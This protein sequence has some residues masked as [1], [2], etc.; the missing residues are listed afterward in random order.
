MP[1][2]NENK[3]GNLIFIK[4]VAKYFMDFLETDFHKRRMPRRSIKTRNND[5]LLIGINL[6]KYASLTKRVLTL[7][8]K[9]FDTNK[10][11]FLIQKGAYTTTLPKNL[12]DLI[13]LQIEN[14]TT[15]QIDNL[16][17]NIAEQIEKAKTFQATEYDVALSNSEVEV[18]KIIQSELVIPFIEEIK[19]SLEK[20]NFGDDNTIYQ[21]EDELTNVIMNLLEDEISEL[22]NRQFANEPVDLLTDI[23]SVFHLKDV[24]NNLNSFFDNLQ[25]GDLFQELFEIDKNNTILDKQDFYLYFGDVTFN[26]TKFP[27]FYIPINLFREEDTYNIEFENQVYINKKAIEYIVQQ[28]NEKQETTGNLKTISNRIIYISENSNLL[29][30][31]INSVLNECSHFFSLN[32]SI[33]L[34]S[35]NNNIA[36]SSL[37]TFSNNCYIALSDKSDEALVNDYEEILEELDKDSGEL[38]SLFHNLLNDFIHNNPDSYTLDVEREWRDSDIP[39]RLVYSSPIPLNSEQRQ[40]L[41]AVQRDNCKYIIVE[42]PPGTGKSHT[43]TAIIFDA[44]LKNQSVLVLSDKKEALDVVEDKITQTM[45]KVRVDDNFQNPI[46]RLGQTGNTYNSILSSSSLKEIKESFFAVDQH[47]KG[48]DKNIKSRQQE[49]KDSIEAEIISYD[50]ISIEEIYEKLEWDEY[51]KDQDLFFDVDHLWDLDTIPEEIVNIFDFITDIKAFLSSNELNNMFSFFEKEFSDFQTIESLNRFS[52]FVLSIIQSIESNIKSTEKEH[53]ETPNFHKLRSQDLKSLI[54][55]LDK[56]V[57]LNNEDSELI[58]QLCRE[59]THLKSSWW[60]LFNGNERELLEKKFKGIFFSNSYSLSEIASDWVSNRLNNYIYQQNH[61]EATYR[62][63]KKSWWSSSSSKQRDELDKKI[64]DIFPNFPSSPSENPEPI[65]RIAGQSS[66][67]RQLYNFLKKYS[68]YNPESV[69][70]RSKFNNSDYDSFSGSNIIDPDKIIKTTGV[71][72]AAFSLN[73]GII[74]IISLVH[75]YFND[76]EDLKE[77]K[78][79]LEKIIGLKEQFQT[80]EEICKKLPKLARKLGLNL[81]SANI[82]QEIKNSN[83]EN[84]ESGFKDQVRYLYLSQ[85]LVNDFNG[86]LDVDYISEKTE[87]ENLVTTQVT[88]TLDERVINFSEN[89]RNDAQALRNIIRNKRRFPRQEFQ[90]LKNAFP[91]ILAGIRDFSEYIPLESELFDL[92]II[93]EASQVSI[94]QAFPALIRA[95]KVVILGDNKQFS[96]IKAQQARS[97]T[98]RLYLNNLSTT[99]KDNISTDAV[100]IERLNKFN[101]KTSILEFFSF[102]SNFNIQLLKYF[103][104]YKEIISYSNDKFYNN[105]QVMKIRGKPIDE[106]I[107]FS[108]VNVEETDEIYPNTNK[109]EVEFIIKELENLNQQEGN[110][111]VGIIT[112]HTNQQKLLFEMISKTN[113]WESYLTKLKLKIMTFDTCQGEERDIIFY[114]M[115]ASEHSDKLWGVFIKDLSKVDIEQDGS[116]KAQRLN[117]GFSRAKEC[118]HFILSK[119]LDEFSGSIGEA[120]RHYQ[121]QLEDA[122]KEKSTTEVDPNSPMEKEVMNWFYQT[123]FYKENKNSID[124]IPQFEIG[125]YLKQLEK[126]YD[127]PKYKVDFLLMYTDKENNEHKIVLEYDGFAEHFRDIGQVDKYNYESFYS[128]DDVYRQKVLESYGYK[129]IR[130]NKFNS[131]T[132]PIEVLNKRIGSLLKQKQDNKSYISRV[133]DT[134]VQLQEG[135][136][137]QCP[138]CKELK[139]TRDFK[140]SSLRTGMGR[141]CSKCKTARSSIKPSTRSSI[142]PSSRSSIKPSSTPPSK[143]YIVPY[144]TK[145]SSEDKLC[146]KC[147]SK[148]ILR[149]YDPNK[150]KKTFNPFYGCSGFPGCRTAVNVSEL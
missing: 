73:N 61:T 137:K 72:K 21:I 80:V 132:N 117:V 47:K 74:D 104:G 124:F 133:R 85:K 14:I 1:Q 129:F 42:G 111:S 76:P 48:I 142:K 40:I 63:L 108:Y 64:E 69:V 65:V 96:N 120:L 122:K 31:T 107:K 109:K 81:G 136:L 126:S 144:T 18:S 36:K 5:N 45:N 68:E 125:T 6:Q 116:I 13:Q 128:D 121:L 139:L 140:D 123:Q 16:I 8:S 27:I 29:V 9:S 17:V 134:N 10:S 38:F 54:Q 82:L 149:M 11:P 37:V 75:K 105:L 113:E 86:I 135:E 106:V 103:R 62:N 79:T 92:V 99:F 119:P 145:K 98:N 41:L 19:T 20:L 26:N 94:A 130:L 147:N 50:D 143:N 32:P 89:S 141:F 71:A 2:L 28:Y 44:I 35:K 49:L 53:Y 57:E 97:D 114:S 83:I 33:D 25:I 101:I 70:S 55:F 34:F 88:H 100:K 118:M 110:I 46:L 51:F 30:D 127:H 43:I 39:D 3:N 23:K 12:I 24:K 146:P 59:Y 87:I 102:I 78:N 95:K 84:I 22:L 60:G 67:Y 150:H 56:T 15:D 131:G 115:V 7:I 93:D 77:I 58:H 66:I 90:K 112:P 52:I 4:E 148:M 138:K 91:C